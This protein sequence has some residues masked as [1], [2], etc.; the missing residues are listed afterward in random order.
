MNWSR[1]EYGTGDEEVI[2]AVARRLEASRLAAGWRGVGRHGAEAP[3][4]LLLRRRTL[5]RTGR[6]VFLADRG[7]GGFSQG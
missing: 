3:C 1:E 2:R 5:R 6:V 4:L 7:W